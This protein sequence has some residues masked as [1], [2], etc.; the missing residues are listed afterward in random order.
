MIYRNPKDVI[1]ICELRKTTQFHNNGYGFCQ[2]CAKSLSIS[3]LDNK[4]KGAELIKN[5]LNGTIS[6][7]ELDGSNHAFLPFMDRMSW[8]ERVGLE[9]LAK[10]HM[11]DDEM[12]EMKDK[13]QIIKDNV[14]ESAFDS[15]KSQIVTIDTMINQLSSIQMRPNKNSLQQYNDKIRIHRRQL[16]RIQNESSGKYRNQYFQ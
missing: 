14:I 6:M 4:L 11:T 1:Y 7:L 13:L 2:R 15:L 10:Q 8:F 5:R 9:Y 16:L 3:E 12:K